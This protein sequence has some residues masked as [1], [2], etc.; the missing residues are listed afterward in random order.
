MA[1]E[2]L[3]RRLRRVVR[4]QHAG[5]ELSVRREVS[6]EEGDENDSPV[7]THCEGH[8]WFSFCDCVA[9]R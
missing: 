8:L 4:C 1:G 9:I 5:A 2:P 7:E 6:R 3:W